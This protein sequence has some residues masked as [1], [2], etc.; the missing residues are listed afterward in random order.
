VKVRA[1]QQA[2]SNVVRFYFRKGLDVR[3]FERGQRSLAGNGAAP[4]VCVRNLK[5]EGAL[6]EARYA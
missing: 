3:G 6:A 5:P 1:K 2:V 4:G